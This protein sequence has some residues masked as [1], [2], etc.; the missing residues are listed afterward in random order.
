MQTIL[1]ASACSAVELVSGQA[2]TD[3]GNQNE[4]LGFKLSKRNQAIHKRPKFL[5]TAVVVCVFLGRDQ[6][7]QS[8]GKADH[9]PPQEEPSILRHLGKVQLQLR[10]AVP[11]AC[12]EACRVSKEGTIVL[13]A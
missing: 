9:V 8:E 12:Q 11:V 6:G 3:L 4:L 1:R 2:F 7:P 5:A 10:E 13:F